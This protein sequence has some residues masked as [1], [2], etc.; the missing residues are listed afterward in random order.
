MDGVPAATNPI[1]YVNDRAGTGLTN[2]GYA[3]CFP[4]RSSYNFTLRAF[5]E[6]TSTERALYGNG[7]TYTEYSTISS[8]KGKRV[9][10]TGSINY[11][12]LTS[13]SI[14]TRS[15]YDDTIPYAESVQPNRVFVSDVDVQSS[16]KNGYRDFKGF[17][18]KDYDSELG[19]ITAIDSFGQLTYII[20]RNG[21]SYIEV[22][23][24]STVSTENG[25]NVY[26]A[27][28]EVLPPK[29]SN[30]V[31]GLGSTHSKSVISTEYGIFGVS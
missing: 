20:F 6:S 24:R 16:F 21:I 5:E 25:N 14:N 26:I 30:I 13:L 28:S 23:E 18:F 3:I 15:Q 7:R 1:T 2:S 19:P 10:E 12:N 9:P 22:S 17:N 31:K 8:I 27:A 29:S 11:G 4:V